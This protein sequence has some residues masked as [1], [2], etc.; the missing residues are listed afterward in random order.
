MQIRNTPTHNIVKFA[1]HKFSFLGCLSIW[2]GA[3][4]I[5]FANITSALAN[6][7]Y[8]MVSLQANE[9]KYKLVI[10]VAQIAMSHFEQTRAE[11]FKRL[12]ALYLIWNQGISPRLVS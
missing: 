9:Y 1:L 3:I 2:Q 7:V 4:F 8:E 5:C 11:E 12:Q 6:V 10:S